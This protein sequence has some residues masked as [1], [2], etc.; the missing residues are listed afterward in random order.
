MLER[1]DMINLEGQ[2]QVIRMNT[3]VFAT[4]IGSLGYQE[5]IP[6]GNGLPHEANNIRARAF[7]SPMNRSRASNRSNSSV[8]S[9]VIV[10][11]FLCST[12][13]STRSDTWDEAFRAIT[14]SGAIS[15]IRPA[16]S[17]NA[18]ETFI[19]VNFTFDKDKLLHLLSKR[20]GTAIIIQL[21]LNSPKTSI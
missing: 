21:P 20:K 13:S 19:V 14:F 3:A 7:V 16:T 11:V 12:N 10:P 5:F 17:P 9:A 6:V 2:K 8:S 18:S 15:A 1:N 4:I